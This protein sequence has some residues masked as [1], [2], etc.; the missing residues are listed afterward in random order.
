M[1]RASVFV[2]QFQ[3]ALS[4]RQH[5]SLKI[6]TKIIFDLLQWQQNHNTTTDKK[7]PFLLSCGQHFAGILPLSQ[8]LCRKSTTRFMS[9]RMRR[10]FSPVKRVSS[11]IL[12]A[13]PWLANKVLRHAIV[14]PLGFADSIFRRGEKRRPEMRLLFASYLKCCCR[15]MCSAPPP[16]FLIFC[17]RIQNPILHFSR[18]IQ[19]PTNDW[20]PANS[21][22]VHGMYMESGIQGVKSRIQRCLGFHYTWGE[23]IVPVLQ[24]RKC[25]VI[26]KF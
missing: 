4:T 9:R 5:I 22:H 18:G 21:F 11:L 20:N 26:P 7:L 16:P 12:R 19:N 17:C 10:H 1:Y 23:G 15:K 8:W 2:W 6:S 24:T 25:T 3:E 13:K 14:L